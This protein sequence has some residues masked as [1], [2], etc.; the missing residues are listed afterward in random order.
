LRDPAQGVVKA[1]VTAALNAK[2]DFDVELVWGADGR[3]LD[4]TRDGVRMLQARAPV[5]PPAVRHPDTGEPT[6]FCNVHSHSSKL[7]KDREEVRQPTDDRPT[8]D[9]A[10]DGRL[11]RAS[12][13]E[14]ASSAAPPSPLLCGGFRA[15]RVV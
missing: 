6:W 1:A 4:G 5:Q 13:L 14:R 3:S 8:D 11:C 9:P 15:M 2:V 7:R 10:T 12:H